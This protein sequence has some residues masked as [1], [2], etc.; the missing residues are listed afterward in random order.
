MQQQK[1][2]PGAVSVTEPVWDERSA[3]AADS[4]AAATAAASQ[5]A[6]NC[7][8]H[9]YFDELPMSQKYTRCR[10]IKHPERITN[11]EEGI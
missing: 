3:A 2:R 1:Q 7:S 4:G 8:L 11:I 9:R 6:L 10:H 5:P